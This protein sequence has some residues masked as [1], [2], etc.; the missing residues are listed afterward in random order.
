M[1][2]KEYIVDIVYFFF[3]ITFIL[4]WI[5]SLKLN[6][7]VRNVLVVIIS[8]LLIIHSYFNISS[9]IKF[10]ETQTIIRKNKLIM[11]LNN[12]LKNLDNNQFIPYKT[13]IQL[14]YN[15]AFIYFSL[16][17][18]KDAVKCFS[19]HFNQLK[20]INVAD[21]VL[22]YYIFCLN[23]TNSKKS[24]LFRWWKNLITSNYNVQLRHIPL[25]VPFQFTFY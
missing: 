11:A 14:N 23:Q 15:N 16:G 9:I 22:D 3:L 17:K 25:P 8:L 1:I 2:Q 20:W 6:K 18:F 12:N 24:K 10:S 4:F 7:P 19:T 5:N 13:R 21:P